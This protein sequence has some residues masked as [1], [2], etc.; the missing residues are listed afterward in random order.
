M[1]CHKN[2]NW[3]EIVQMPKE[4]E[5]KIARDCAKFF[6]LQGK[7]LAIFI[8]LKMFRFYLLFLLLKRYTGIIIALISCIKHLNSI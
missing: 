3:D 8:A 1:L 5:V 4:V 6:S 2:F 7:L